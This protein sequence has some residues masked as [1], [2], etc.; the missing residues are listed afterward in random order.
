MVRVMFEGDKRGCDEV[1][2]MCEGDEGRVMCEGDEERVMVLSLQ[3]HSQG[4]C[5]EDQTPV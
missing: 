1:R 4:Y 3:G 2:V 5:D